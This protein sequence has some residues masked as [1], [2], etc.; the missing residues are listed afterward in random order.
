MSAESAYTSV[1]QVA[2]AFTKS[3]KLGWIKENDFILDYGG[4]KYETSTNY[5]EE[6]GI[7]SVVYDPF[8]RTKGHNKAALSAVKDCVTH[9]YCNNVLNV[10]KDDAE[11]HEI[12]LDILKQ[13]RRSKK[14]KTIVFSVYEG[15]R[16][17]IPG[18]RTSQLNRK[19][20][21][22][23]DEIMA[24]INEVPFIAVSVSVKQKM[25]LVDVMA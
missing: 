10:I 16:T 13:S 8:H 2:S 19:T 12:I 4:G 3:V 1:N 7:Y 9:I 24:G 11:R 23:V 14:C 21:S 15:N 6:L 22:Y 20:D 17:G 25:I 18:T 5:L